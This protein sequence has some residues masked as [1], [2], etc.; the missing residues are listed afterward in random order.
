[1]RSQSIFAQKID[2]IRLSLT[3]RPESLLLTI[4]NYA[5]LFLATLCVCVQKTRNQIK[6]FGR[7]VSHHIFLIWC[8]RY[9]DDFLFD[10]K[11]DFSL[12]AN[13]ELY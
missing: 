12:R 5:P 1:M 8:K 13:N 4:E 6:I 10:H 9:R 7:A 3:F 11:I 2:R